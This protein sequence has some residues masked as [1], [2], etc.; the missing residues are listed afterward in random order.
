MVGAL[1]F[2]TL[3]SL[4]PAQQYT[5]YLPY[6]LPLIYS[7]PDVIDT[8]YFARWAF[9]TDEGRDYGRQW[10]E[11]RHQVHEYRRQMKLKAKR[12]T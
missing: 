6:L 4:Q 12:E 11:Y 1:G 5:S 2:V 10:E 3:V 7:L 9:K 8:F